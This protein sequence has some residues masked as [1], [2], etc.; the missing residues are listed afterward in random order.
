MA[1]YVLER[2]LY[3]FAT[4]Q[5]GRKHFVLKGGL[6]LDQFGARRT[7]RDIDLLGQ[8]FTSRRAAGGRGQQDRTREISNHLP[9]TIKSMSMISGR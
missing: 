2:L 6:L 9:K 3:R 7:T 8:A 5:A 4:S 1:E